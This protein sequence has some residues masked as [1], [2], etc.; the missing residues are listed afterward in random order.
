[1]DMGVLFC[2]RGRH[3]QCG[4]KLAGNAAIDG[5]IAAAET[6][7]QAQWR[8]IS[9]FQVINLCAAL[10]QSIDQMTDRTLFHARF[11]GQ[12]H[13][14]AAQAQSGCQ[15]THRGTGIAEEQFKRLAG[16]QRAANTVHFTGGAIV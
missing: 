16:H 9:L 1:M 11:A 4:Q 15:W 13:I 10:T 7:A 14:V 2:Q 8:I 5:D 3:Q 12:H 6:A